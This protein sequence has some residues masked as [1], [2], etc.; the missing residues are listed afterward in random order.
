MEKLI[1]IGSIILFIAWLITMA[2][3]IAR[4]GVKGL[5]NATDYET[6][7]EEINSLL[8]AP[9]M[10]I[11]AKNYGDLSSKLMRLTKLPHK[12]KERTSVLIC[13][14]QKKFGKIYCET[15]IR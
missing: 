13:T 9:D 12:D 8:K 7:H 5:I 2:W 4:A 10:A 6:L 3:I 14:F 11:N 15:L 1:T